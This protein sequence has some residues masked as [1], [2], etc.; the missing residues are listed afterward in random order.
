MRWSPPSAAATPMREVARRFGV[1]L[2]TVQLW[3]ARAGTSGWIASTGRTAPTA[4]AGR[5]TAPPHDLE[6]LVL[7]LRA[8]AEGHQRPGRVRRRGHPPAPW[9]PAA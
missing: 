3:V 1:A 2:A 7:T 4:H 8:R 9:R 6:D 5:P